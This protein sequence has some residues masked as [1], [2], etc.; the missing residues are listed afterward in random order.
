MLKLSS[1]KLLRSFSSL[2]TDR[3]KNCQQFRD[4]TNVVSLNPDVSLPQSIQLG[5]N[6][7]TLDEI[8]NLSVIDNQLTINQDAALSSLFDYS[9][10][11]LIKS[12]D[13][14]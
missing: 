9:Q 1:P 3:Q 11:T 12:E 5:G 2:Q 7:L 4:I 6:P 14:A 13:L 10:C 8:C